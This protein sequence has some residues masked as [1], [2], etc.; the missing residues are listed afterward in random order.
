VAST[1][2][3]RSISDTYFLYSATTAVPDANSEPN[4]LYPALPRLLLPNCDRL[5]TLTSSIPPSPPFP[6]PIAN[7]TASILL[8]RGSNCPTAID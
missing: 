8:C 7:L 3:L 6:A 2:E 5:A 4:C 1:A